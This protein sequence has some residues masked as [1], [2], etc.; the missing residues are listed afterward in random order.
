MRWDAGWYLAIASGGYKWDPAS[1]AQQT[2]AFFP[3]YP[4][5]MRPAWWIWEDPIALIWTGVAI[6]VMAFLAALVLF[7]RLV[8]A[9]TNPETATAAVMLL[10]AY[11]FAVFYSA[12]YT[13]ALFLL[14]LVGAIHY[15]EEERFT[16]SSAFGL[17]AGLSRPNG[18]MLASV[19]ALL[20]F[21][22]WWRTRDQ[23]FSWRPLAG[24][25]LAVAAPIVGLL[26]Y[27]VF[28]YTF[29]GDPLTWAKL[30]GAWNRHFR[31]IDDTLVREG[32]VLKQ[33]G[34]V[35]YFARRPTEALNGLATLLALLA[36]WP[37]YRRFG[38]AYGWLV[39]SNTIVPLLFGGLLSMGRLTSIQF[40]VFMW[41]AASSSPGWRQAL[42]MLFAFGQAIVAALFFTWRPMF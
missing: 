17:L 8:R 25:A 6:S 16:R 14:G 35:A 34:A 5:L 20:A 33:I 42:I 40:P 32:N 13:E 36:I 12:P 22:A 41:L 23:P 26:G 38:A 10:A 30:H 1:T 27:C 3:A 9:K 21:T 2:P 29:T 15:F 31:W 4:L 7:Y 19:L 24:P 11:P 28:N 18:W 39:A 37:V